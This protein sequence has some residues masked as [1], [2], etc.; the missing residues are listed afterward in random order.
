MR[1]KRLFSIVWFFSL[2]GL[3]PSRTIADQDVVISGSINCAL[4]PWL[5]PNGPILA[6]L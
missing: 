6:S 3:L 2:V 1:L 4:V 5:M